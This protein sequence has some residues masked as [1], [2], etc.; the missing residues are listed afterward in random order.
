MRN[1]YL[2]EAYNIQLIEEGRRDRYESMLKGVFDVHTA[3]KWIDQAIEHYKRED[4]IIWF[5]RWVKLVEV[6][7]NMHSFETGQYD[8]SADI[9]EFRIKIGKWRENFIK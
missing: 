9:E 7:R 5:L 6:N 8:R 3:D 4:R 2:E 1:H